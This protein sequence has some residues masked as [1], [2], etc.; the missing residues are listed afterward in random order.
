MTTQLS[1]RADDR[2]GIYPAGLLSQEFAPMAI[3]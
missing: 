2:D 3:A 1:G